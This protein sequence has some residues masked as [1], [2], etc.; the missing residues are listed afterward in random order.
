M[1]KV[2]ISTFPFAASDAT[3]TRLLS[4]A[5]IEYLINPIGRKLKED[6]LADL[7]GDHDVLIAGTEQITD[8]VMARAS[9]LRLISRVGIG[10]D[11][12]DL[13]ATRK[14]GIHVAYAPDAP[15]NAVADLT[16]GLMI[17]LLRQVHVSN[18]QLHAGRW[19]RLFGRRLGEVTVG[20]IGLGRIGTGVLARLQGFGCPRILANDIRQNRSL[21]TAF[22]FKWSTKEEIFREAD[23]IS[24][25]VPLTK[26]TRNL[27]GRT[28]LEQMKPA[29]L[30]VNTARGG[31]IN[32]AD[33][34]AVM[35]A[36]HL[37]GAA[38][39][40]FEA[41]PYDGPLREIERCVL[42]AHM[43]SMS[44]DCRTRMEI[45]ATAEAVRFLTGQALESEVPE[46]EYEN[47]R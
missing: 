17:C 6:E 28:E 44:F 21:E 41:E 47:Q 10:L 9:R 11:G 25:H 33:L 20:L 4:A 29:A 14:R 31:I 16:L 43:G 1:P 15:A 42:T 45:E 24:V 18:A 36:G 37:G 7:I 32:E 30:I 23:V 26:L 40:V 27:I 34:H 19:T 5:G 46:D 38:I 12:V 22:R 2:L 39:D 3:P 13:V 8:K 35:K